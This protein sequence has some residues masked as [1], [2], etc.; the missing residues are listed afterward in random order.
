MTLREKV[1]R[2]LN[3]PNLPLDERASLDFVLEV[4][5]ED[6]LEGMLYPDVDSH[7]TARFEWYFFSDGT[8]RRSPQ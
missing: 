8:F 6:E 4:N 7:I 1:V 3:V 5:G 2:L